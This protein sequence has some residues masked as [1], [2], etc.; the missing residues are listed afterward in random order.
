MSIRF[1]IVA[2]MGAVLL[3]AIGL[4]LALATRLLTRDKLAYIYDLEASLGATLS[5]EV[6]GNVGTLVDKLTYFAAE[7]VDGGPAAARALL[8]SDPDLLAAEVWERRDGRFVRVARHVERWRLEAAGLTGED[9][10]AS[11]RDAAIPFEAVAAGEV[12]LQNASLPPDGAVLSIAAPAHGGGRV[13]V[14]AVRPDRLLRIFART[15][16]FRAYLVDGAG[17]VLVHPDADQVIARASL[18]SRPIV[19][20]AIR[21]HV[22]RGARDVDGPGGRMIAAFAHVGLGRLSVIVEVPRDEALRA[23]R[24]L[25]SRS[26][27]FGLG[28]LCLALVASV[29]F[30]NRL[31]APLRRLEAATRALGRG[32]FEVEVGAAP[33][34]EIGRLAKAFERMRRDIADRD[35]RIS[36]AHTELS[37]TGKLSIIGELAAS[38][39]HEVKNPL[40][41]IVG[42]AQ[43]G[44][45][46]ADVEEARQLFGIVEEHA[47]RASKILTTML[48]FVRDAK[49]TIGE[50]DAAALVDD[51]LRLLG[52][53]LK[54]KGI[55]LEK[56]LDPSTPRIAGSASELQQVLVNLMLNAADAMDGCR[57]KRLTIGT[58]RDGSFGVLSVSDT[59]RGI[60]PEAQERLFTP[61]FTTK[62]AGQGTGLGLSVSQRIVRQHGGDIR[63]RTEPGIGTV[64]TVR[65]PLA[66]ADTAPPAGEAAAG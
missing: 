45:T 59:G 10:A 32:D 63:A 38:V 20:E 31:T 30:A 56:A 16:A 61:F 12:V 1:Q 54:M 64:F 28:A 24:Q 44:R 18:A 2:L 5:E 51:A 19:A 22:A 21:G 27:L 7:R 35:A 62:P 60:S 4:Y 42:Y 34:G 9:L 58:G 47:W 66:A 39:A 65:I 8:S 25:L 11:W 6:R 23:T 40:S 13:V 53:Q 50:L 29:Y 49:P 57:D 33:A 41:A 48:G 37:L 43:F 36:E 26:V 46:A 52:P 55:R 3:A 14:A 15:T 17:R